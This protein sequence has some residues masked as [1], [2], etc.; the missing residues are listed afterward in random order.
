VSA[1]SPAAAVNRLA[2]PDRFKKIIVEGDP[3]VYSRVHIGAASTQKSNVGTSESLQ[4]DEANLDFL[5]D[6]GLPGK[7]GYSYSKPWDYFSFQITGSSVRPL[8]SVH[9]R[10]LIIGAPYKLGSHYDGIWGLYGSLDYLAP[11]LF[12]LSS[13]ALSIGSTA[14]W[15][16]SDNIAVQGTATA[17]YG[18]AATGTIDSSAERDYNYGVAPQALLALRLIL[19][20]TASLD[21]NARKY[22]AGK[23]ANAPSDGS[24]QVVR[25]DASLTMR[26]KRHHAVSI[27]YVTSRRDTFFP[28]LEDRYQRR[29]TVGFFYTYLVDGDMGLVY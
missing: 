4:H 5:L 26:L 22:F 27:K 13:T 29:D 1:I 6:Y 2:F 7:A 17:G 9:N 11:Q 16:L 15:R 21:L 12:R 23:I 28:G 8:E 25:A 20:N 18:F 19:G 3:A 10:G 14:Q 24:D